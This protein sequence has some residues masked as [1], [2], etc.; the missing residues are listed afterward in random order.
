MIMKRILKRLLRPFHTPLLDKFKSV[1]FHIEENRILIAQQLINEIYAKKRIPARLSDAEFKV[2]SQWGEDGIIQF[3]ISRVPITNEIFVEFGVETYQESNTRFLLVNNNWKGLIIDS[4]SACIKKIQENDLY[5]RHDL[6]A[7]N[8]FITKDNINRLIKDSG[9]VGDIGLLSIDV[10]G[11]DYWIWKAIDVISPRIVICEY[12]S[13]FGYREA[14]TIPYDEK[15]DRTLS[16]YS[17]LYYGASLRALCIL[18][19]KKGYVFVGSN[20]AGCNAFF[21]RKDVAGKISSIDCKTGYVKS[22]LRDS[23][24]EKGRLTFVSGDDR[25]KFI[26]DMTVIDILTDREKRIREMKFY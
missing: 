22:R 10:D 23:R 24:D 17:N 20:K 12:N 18:A 3:L 25:M 16:H 2:F 6:T 26:Q 7:L 13:P 4:N 14:V 15:F 21:I 11:N 5:W 8:A 9:I 19:R 1:Q